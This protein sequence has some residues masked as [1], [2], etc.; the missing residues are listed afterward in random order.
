MNDSEKNTIIIGLLSLALIILMFSTSGEFEPYDSFN[1]SNGSGM[2]LLND[3]F[4]V[5]DRNAGPM[6]FESA[7]YYCKRRGMELPTREQAWEM[8]RASA[9]CKISMVLNN[10]IIKDK[11]TF[12]KSCHNLDKNC[13]VPSNQVNY[14]CAP[15]KDLLFLDEK[16]FRYGNYWLKDRYDRN[17]HY[18]ANFINGMTNAYADNIKLLGVRCVQAAA[19]KN[20]EK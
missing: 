14:F 16:V 11:N 12:I 7:E 3:S 13:L 10:H 1:N 5:D 8:W 4:Y 2:T 19:N 20:E 17:G 6:D 18:S 15:D 9:N